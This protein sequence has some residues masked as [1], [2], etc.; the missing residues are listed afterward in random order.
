MT[1]GVWRA[2]LEKSVYSKLFKKDIKKQM[3]SKPMEKCLPILI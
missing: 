3:G 2:I 1:C